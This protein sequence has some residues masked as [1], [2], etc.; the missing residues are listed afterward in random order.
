MTAK[1]ETGSDS[2]MSTSP[3]S[4]LETKRA[5]RHAEEV[6]HL[7]APADP[8]LKVSKLNFYCGAHQ[9]IGPSGCRKSTFLLAMNRIQETICNVRLDGK[10][11]LANDTIFEHTTNI[12]EDVLLVLQGFDM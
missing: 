7:A 12:P 9:A 4:T 6:L 10:L 8:K 5:V 11:V 3:K 1:D 2:R